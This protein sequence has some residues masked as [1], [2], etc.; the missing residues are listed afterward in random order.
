MQSWKTNMTDEDHQRNL[1]DWRRQTRADAHT[2]RQMEEQWR[3]E[4]E[5]LEALVGLRGS[6]G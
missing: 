1:E 4:A 6:D 2:A 5:R 3:R